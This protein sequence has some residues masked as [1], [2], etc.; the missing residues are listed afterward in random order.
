M[1]LPTYLPTYLLSN[2]LHTLLMDDSYPLR[3]SPAVLS[4]WPCKIIFLHLS[5][6]IYFFA[7]PSIKLKQGQQIGGGLLIANHLDQSLW[8]AAAVTSYLL[9][10]SLQVHTAAVPFT[11]HS[12]V[13]SYAEPKPFSWAKPAYIRFS[14]SNCT[15]QDHMPSTIGH[16]LRAYPLVLSN[17]TL[18]NKIKC[19]SLGVF[20][21]G[22]L[23]N[24]TVTA[25]MW[26][27]L[28]ANHLDQS[29]WSTNQKYWAAVRS[30]LLQSFLN[31]VAAFISHGSSTNLVQKN[32]FH[33][34]NRHVLTFLQ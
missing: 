14:S 29:L 27:L 26:G 25:Y 18:D 7:T 16:A 3:A 24:T 19:L 8:W 11:N 22:N 6:V 30:N 9:H 1:Y 33:E 5:L 15:L 28:I 2:Q 23:T 21:F 13:R 10:S 12:S 32:K 17:V 34:L 20:F 31:C 4:M